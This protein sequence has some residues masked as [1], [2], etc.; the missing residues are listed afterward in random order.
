MKGKSLTQKNG[1][2]LSAFFCDYSYHPDFPDP[3]AQFGSTAPVA[4][5]KP[6]LFYRICQRRFL[7]FSA[8]KLFFSVS[9]HLSLVF[10]QLQYFGHMALKLLQ[11]AELLSLLSMAQVPPGKAASGFILQNSF[12]T[13]LLLLP[14]CRLNRPSVI[15]L[16]HLPSNHFCLERFCFKE[17]CEAIFSLHRVFHKGDVIVGVAALQVLSPLRHEL[18]RF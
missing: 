8:E 11:I 3:V 9:S 6:H 1:S 16:R 7:R 13:S 5:F 10:L 15:L 14:R 2:R 18:Y 17:F 4:C 12:G